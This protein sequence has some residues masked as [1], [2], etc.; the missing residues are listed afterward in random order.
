M[1]LGSTVAWSSQGVSRPSTLIDVRW[2]RYVQ[3]IG[4]WLR[5]LSC[6]TLVKLTFSWEIS[7]REDNMST[8]PRPETWPLVV[9][10]R[11]WV[12]KFAPESSSQE[13]SPAVS[14]HVVCALLSGRLRQCGARNYANFHVVPKNQFPIQQITLCWHFP[15]TILTSN[16]RFRPCYCGCRAFVSSVANRWSHHGGTAG[17][18]QFTKV[19]YDISTRVTNCGALQQ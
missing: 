7:I 10:L 12:K 8:N 4:V 5:E 9:T 17:F 16:S 1:I 14:Q 2:G 15:A 18:T 13:V 19:R 3:F 11:K 6:V